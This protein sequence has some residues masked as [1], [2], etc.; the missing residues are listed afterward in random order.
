M[1]V[2]AV[3]TLSPVWDL[4]IV[5]FR[6]FSSSGELSGDPLTLFSQAKVEALDLSSSA[7]ENWERLLYWPLVLV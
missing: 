1:A 4:V 2:D 7:L 5:G 3:A 6:L